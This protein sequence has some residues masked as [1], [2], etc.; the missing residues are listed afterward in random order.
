MALTVIESIAREI[1]RRLEKIKSV[2]GYAFNVTKVVRPDRNATWTPEDRLIL[3]KQGDSIKNA[4]L[5]YPGNPPA[6]AFD[7]VFELCGFVRTSDFCDKEYDPIEND[8]GAQIIKAITTEATD[9]GSWYT[10][11]GKAVI[12][13]ITEVRSFEESESHNGVIVSLSVTH[14]QD[15]NNP[16][17]VRA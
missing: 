3:V 13:D 2:N 1:V 4:E 7:T 8:R 12:S 6:V 14:R 9:P 10:F 11:A 15:E 5:S 17:N 16:Y